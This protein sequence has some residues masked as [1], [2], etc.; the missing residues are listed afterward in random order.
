MGATSDT[1]R[2]LEIG[3]CSRL[4]G[5]LQD[6]RDLCGNLSGDLC[7]RAGLRRRRPEGGGEEAVGCESWLGAPIPPVLGD[8]AV[9]SC[10]SLS[11]R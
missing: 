3:S 2:P 4:A 8:P 10:V 9:A 5:C 1:G 7:G 6:R 11:L